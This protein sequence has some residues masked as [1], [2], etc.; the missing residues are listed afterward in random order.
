MP[1]QL[2]PNPTAECSTPSPTSLPPRRSPPKR[3]A[4]ERPRERLLLFGPKSLSET[5]L[6]ALLLG[7]GRAVQRAQAVLDAVGGLN[8]LSRACA[9]ELREVIGIG[10]AGA[11]ALAAAVELHRRLD[12]LDLP[13]RRPLRHPREAERFL[14]SL[15]GDAEREHFMI[16]GL[17]AR[18]RVLLVRTIA[19]GSLTRV[20][21]HPREVFRPLVRA[22][23]HTCLLVHNHPSGDAR[24]SEADIELT[25]RMTD[26]GRF[27]GIPVLDHVVVS[28]NG[29]VSL[30]ELGLVGRGPGDLPSLSSHPSP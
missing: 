24:P 7:G 12:R 3:K 8:G 1:L 2:V 22:G 18:Q 9:H 6:L 30:A 4:Q 15:L 26:I 19:V 16:I 25:A 10:D 5:E 20:E 23:A 29:F 21:V 14:R 11:T 17:D 13:M 28:A 27:L